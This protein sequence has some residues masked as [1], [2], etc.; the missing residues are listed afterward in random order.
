MLRDLYV[1]LEILKHLLPSV[2][3]LRRLCRVVFESEPKLRGELVPLRLDDQ[4]VGLVV[5][6]EE[7][8]LVPPLAGDHGA[9]ED[10]V[11]DVDLLA[12][13]LLWQV[14]GQDLVQHAVDGDGLQV[15]GE[16]LH[17]VVGEHDIAGRPEPEQE[18]ED[19]AVEAGGE[20]GPEPVGEDGG[21]NLGAVLE[22]VCP[23][24]HSD[25]GQ[26]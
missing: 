25:L 3:A 5:V 23:V 22:V 24:A 9:P 21:V 14:Q 13:Q 17:V 26:E 4:V 15:L 18:V 16:V 2:G 12:A 19:E 1:Q 10:E 7:E 8:V 11:P 20:A 6:P